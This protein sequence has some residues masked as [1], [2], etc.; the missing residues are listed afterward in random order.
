MSLNRR[1]FI[2]T[3]AL[4][5]LSITTFACSFPRIKNYNII[6]DYDASNSVFPSLTDRIELPKN[7]RY[8]TLISWGDNIFGGENFDILNPLKSN[9]KPEECFGYN[10]DFCAYFP[11]NNSSEHGI[12]CVNHEYPNPEL[13]FSEEFL[14]DNYIE[15][16][17]IF[18]AA[19][20]CSIIEIKK[21]NNDWQI[22]KNSKFNRRITPDTI[23]QISGAVQGS[24]RIHNKLNEADLAFGTFANCSGGKTPWNTYLTAEENFDTFFGG[25]FKDSS[26]AE[27]LNYLDFSTKS[28]YHLENYFPR[29]NLEKTPNEAN[30]FGYIV[31]IDPFSPTKT[32]VK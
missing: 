3:S 27:N 11:I 21:I 8:Q 10:N 12:L 2:K 7:Y 20:G 24:A 25:D 29:F 15:A 16:A 14:K 26:E 17:K 9:S 1:D 22:V 28:K 6:P 18:M 19:L 23:C 30:K 13:M 31:E 4:S 5:F 32:P